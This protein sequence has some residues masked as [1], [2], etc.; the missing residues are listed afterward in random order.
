MKITEDGSYDGFPITVDLDK[1]DPIWE[2]LNIWQKLEI[3]TDTII[4][5]AEKR[6]ADK[7]YKNSKQAKRIK[8]LR[9]RV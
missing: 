4:R 8:S 1:E 7:D 6:V 2:N 9:K 5:S 3:S